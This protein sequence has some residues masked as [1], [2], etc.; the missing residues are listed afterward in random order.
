MKE[1]TSDWTAEGRGLYKHDSWKKYEDTDNIQ[2]DVA[3]F[4]YTWSW[5]QTIRIH[6]DSK[7]I[8]YLN[9]FQLPRTVFHGVC[10][11]PY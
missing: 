8:D 9:Y 2:V 5:Q 4:T 6:E 7:L 3:R 1:P 10:Y 11:C